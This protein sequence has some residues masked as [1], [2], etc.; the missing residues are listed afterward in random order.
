[1]K[2]PFYTKEHCAMVY[3]ELKSVS[4]LMHVLNLCKDV[5]FLG[6]KNAH[7]EGVGSIAHV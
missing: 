4:K 6:T 3:G 7:A 5:I 1:M 2:C